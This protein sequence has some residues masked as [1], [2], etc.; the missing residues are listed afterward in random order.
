MGN[1][2]TFNDIQNVHTQLSDMRLEYWLSDNLFTFQWWLLLFT[3]FLPWFV[4][5]K[6]VD[7]KR[8]THILLYGT[9]L[10]ILVSIL[11]DMGVEA[12]LWSY[13][14]QLA[15]IMPRLIP[16]DL[17]II[18]VAHMFLYQ[19]FTKW[20]TFILAN[21]IMAIIFTFIFEP[22]TVWL[23]IYKLENWRYIYSLPIYI[24]KAALMKWVV[25]KLIEKEK[26]ANKI[27]Y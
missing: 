20:K 6:F 15:N 5:W 8:C 7:K 13:P 12:H 2:T 21:L 25:D 11:D 27:K 10:M 9:L 23:G 1:T 16:I 26:T 3:L 4:W 18:V 17:G 19:Y 14:Y 24:I 22:I